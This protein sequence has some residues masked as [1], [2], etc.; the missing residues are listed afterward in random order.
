MLEKLNKILESSKIPEATR[1]MI[2]NLDEDGKTA[3][4]DLYDENFI[5]MKKV[6]PICITIQLLILLKK[7]FLVKLFI[8]GLFIQ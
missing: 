4:N 1:K 6:L 8:L 3:L 2:D 7:L 5:P